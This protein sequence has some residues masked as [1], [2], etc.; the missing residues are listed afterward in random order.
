M[1]LPTVRLCLNEITNTGLPLNVPVSHSLRK[2]HAAC[3]FP[4]STFALLRAGTHDH[5]HCLSTH[6][7]MYNSVCIDYEHLKHYYPVP[8]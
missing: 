8:P 1:F 3:T 7:F 4:L 5:T 6:T 2:M